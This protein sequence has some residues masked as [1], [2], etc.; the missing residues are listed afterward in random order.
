MADEQP[1]F[2]REFVLGFGFFSGLW[3]RLGFDPEARILAFVT[4]YVQSL[5]PD[6]SVLI[7][8]QI[9][10]ILVTVA[11]VLGAFIYGRTLGVIAVGCA[12]A[13]GLYIPSVSGIVFAIGA[14]GVGILA[15]RSA[16]K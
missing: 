14:I 6:Q 12:F 11:S 5:H 7:F 16:V 10:P 15:S 1:S 13:A 8:F 2:L 3:F 9:L 4:K